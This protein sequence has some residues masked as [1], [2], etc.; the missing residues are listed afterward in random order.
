[1]EARKEPPAQAIMGTLYVGNFKLKLKRPPKSQSA[2]HCYCISKS[3]QCTE[4]GP[5]DHLLPQWCPGPCLMGMQ[6][7]PPVMEKTGYNRDRLKEQVPCCPWAGRA[8]GG[9]LSSKEAQLPAERSGRHGQC[10]LSLIPS[11][12]ALVATPSCWGSEAFPTSSSGHR[13]NLPLWSSHL[14]SLHTGHTH[15]T[16][17]SVP[18]GAAA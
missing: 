10:H 18:T 12:G 9:Q 14:S 1:V 4:K 13:G 15:G 17:S 8:H 2:F 16:A 7:C 6:P 11:T 5:P 3:R